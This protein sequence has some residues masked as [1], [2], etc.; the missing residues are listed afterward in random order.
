MKLVVSDVNIL[1]VLTVFIN[2][3][4]IIIYKNTLFFWLVNQVS[5]IIYICEHHWKW[6]FYFFYYMDMCAFSYWLR[7]SAINHRCCCCSWIHY[8]E[9]TLN[10]FTNAL[11][12]IPFVKLIKKNLSWSWFF[13]HIYSYYWCQDPLRQVIAAYL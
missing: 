5:F 8:I 4:A 11:E 3:Y 9:L 1:R 12:F 2:K 13:N 10:C 7:F 6:L